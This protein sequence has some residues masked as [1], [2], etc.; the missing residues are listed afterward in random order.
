MVFLVLMTGEASLT[1]NDLPCVWLMAS[2]A[3]Q[4]RMFTHFVQALGTPMAGFAIG[5][6][7]NFRLLKM[8]CFALHLHHRSRGIN[9]V[10]G[11]TVQGWPKACPMAKVAENPVVFPLQR[12]WMP[13][14]GA[15]RRD[16]PQG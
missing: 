10:T 12:P 11:D 2:G 6:R 1:A 7:Q 9:S 5:H 3:R 14:L 13:R 15:D 4:R 16:G 8:A